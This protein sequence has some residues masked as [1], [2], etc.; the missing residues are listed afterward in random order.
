[1][2]GG[3]GAASRRLEDIYITFGVQSNVLAQLTVGCLSA[4]QLIIAVCM[5]S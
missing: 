2:G 1:M 4:V 3:G 5:F